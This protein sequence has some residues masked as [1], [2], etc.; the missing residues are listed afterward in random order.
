MHKKTLIVGAAVFI[1]G[2]TALAFYVFGTR[3]ALGQSGIEL[4]GMD[5]RSDVDVEA[6]IDSASRH[7]TDRWEDA[8]LWELTIFGVSTD[9]SLDMTDRLSAASFSFASPIE[10]ATYK[11]GNDRDPPC[12]YINVTPHHVVKQTRGGI[13]DECQPGVVAPSFDTRPSCTFDEI[14]TRVEQ[15]RDVP[16]DVSATVT[17][18]PDEKGGAWVILGDRG[19]R[20]DVPDTC[21][22]PGE[23]A[24]QPEEATKRQPTMLD[25]LCDPDT[26]DGKKCR[27]CPDFTGAEPGSGPLTLV[28]KKKVSITGFEDRLLTF[29]GCAPGTARGV[30]S[31]LVSR[32]EGTW[33]RLS[34]LV[35]VHVEDCTLVDRPDGYNLAACISKTATRQG[36]IET[37][38]ALEPNFK[39]GAEARPLLHV[40]NRAATCDTNTY[41]LDNINDVHAQD[42]DGDG[43]EDLRVMIDRRQGELPP[44]FETSCDDGFDPTPG[45]ER[46]TFLN[47]A[48]KL[49]RKR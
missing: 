6:M 17:Y 14:W 28:A 5:D 34:H 42:F 44:T 26:I 11:M 7:A 31:V 43:D 39:A 47:I 18:R 49:E 8:V 29:E 9:G 19:F 27:L 36:T 35:G 40:E 13:D 41:L 4:S 1:V 37:L 16:E 38:V 23:P 45:S 46:V 48:G 25:A 10:H 20:V 15:Q 22:V 2:V 3:S 30:S 24:E 33:Q 32:R 21:E 12:M